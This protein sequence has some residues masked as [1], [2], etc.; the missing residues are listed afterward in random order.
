MSYKISSDKIE[1][2][3]L[4]PLLE[5]LI[6]FFEQQEVK[7]FVIGATARDIILEINGEQPGRR[8]QD[9]DIAITIDKWEQFEKISE[10]L[11]KLE[12]FSKDKEQKQRFLYFN[13]FQLDMVP[14]GGIM[15]E[16]DK[17]YWPPDQN[18]A[19]N[20]LGFKE[21]Q[22]ETV[23]ITLDE[24]IEFE[25]VDLIGIFLLKI[26]A[27][28]DRNYKGNKDAD[29]M[30]F[31]LQNYLNINEERAVNKYYDIVYSIEDFTVLKASAALIGID[32]YEL[33][34][35]NIKVVEYVIDILEEE[36]SKTERSILINQMIE[37][38]NILKFDDIFQS[39]QIIINTLKK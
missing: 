1:H 5:E 21:V 11:T 28:K 22:K 38:H 32:L 15:E 39:I 13:K 3:L 16:N 12:N 18:F 8:T 25:V 30:A 24:K 33:I 29:D 27:W 19:M 4:K 23:S 7:F 17:I 9:I 26:V 35:E 14:Y 2:P 10:E 31:I 36:I 6:P 37:T 20:V 34:K